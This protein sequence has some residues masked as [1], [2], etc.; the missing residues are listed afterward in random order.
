MSGL[1]DVYAKLPHGGDMRLLDQVR[2]WDRDGIHCVTGSHR[3][4]A[5]P[6]RRGG[7]LSAVHAVE[8]AAQAA[9]VHGVL[10]SVLDGGPVL[11]LAAVRD[12]EL[13]LD[14]L[15]T[16]PGPLQ[17]TARLEARA[18]ANAVYR[19][20]L[21]SGGRTCARGAITLMQG[22]ETSA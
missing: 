13:D 10:S 17:I 9:A 1:G 18:G 16:L 8:Y 11:L 7:T 15:D 2:E 22:G 6:L 5:N 3:S 21:D 19:F 4:E 12:L 20:A 14:R